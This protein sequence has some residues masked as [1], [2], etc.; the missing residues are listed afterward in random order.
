MQ[1]ITNVI[2]NYMRAR[3]YVSMLQSLIK[4]GSVDQA[5]TSDDRFGTYV[6][7]VFFA[8]FLLGAVY[9][10]W[11]DQNGTSLRLSQMSWHLPPT[12]KNCL[13]YKNLL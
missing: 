6:G 3:A 2:K 1:W 8:W 5:S 7:S 13:F 12:C 9:I 11:Y 10:N 4:F